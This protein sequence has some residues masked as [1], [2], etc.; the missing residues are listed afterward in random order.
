MKRALIFLTLIIS[1]ACSSTGAAFLD[2]GFSARSEAMGS[3]FTA[4]ANDLDAFYYNPGGFAL[5]QN[6]KFNSF[7]TKVNNMQNVFYSGI[8]ARVGKIFL[9]FNFQNTSLTDIPITNYSGGEVVDTGDSFNYSSSAMFFS[10][11]SMLG[12]YWSKLDKVSLGFSFKVLS[13]KLYDNSAAGS[14]MD[15]GIIYAFS[16]DLKLGFSIINLV[17]PIM[18][19]DTDSSHQDKVDRYYRTGISYW[20]DKDLLIAYDLIID[21]DES[22]NNLGIEYLVNEKMALR[23]GMMDADYSIGLGLLFNQFNFDY[24]FSQPYDELQEATHKLRGRPCRNK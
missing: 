2:S 4:V 14:G 23:A 12:D 9:A 19:W 11:A 7:Y 1:M 5:Q 24:S 10:A 15:L 3:A 20:L 13:E 6:G 16:D 8:G 22:Q 21:P 18:T 17:E